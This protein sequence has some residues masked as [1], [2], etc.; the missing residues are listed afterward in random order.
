MAVTAMCV[1]PLSADST[2][3]RLLCTQHRAAISLYNVPQYRFNPDSYIDR[4][5]TTGVRLCTRTGLHIS[6]VGFS[7]PL[8]SALKTQA[9]KRLPPAPTPNWAFEAGTRGF[10]DM[11]FKGFLGPSW[12]TAALTRILRRQVYYIKYL[13]FFNFFFRRASLPASRKTLCFQSSL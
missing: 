7:M 3:G 12:E 4:V 6:R 8:E 9:Q 1:T 10:S 13:K 11:P 5:T 2:Q